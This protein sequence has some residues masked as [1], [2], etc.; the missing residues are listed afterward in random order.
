MMHSLVNHSSPYYRNISGQNNSQ[1]IGPE[2]VRS[3]LIDTLATIGSDVVRAGTRIE[4][5]T[6]NYHDDS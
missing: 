2:T 3:T 1:I 4:I 6:S 5:D